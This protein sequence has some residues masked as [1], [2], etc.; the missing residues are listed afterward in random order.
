IIISEKMIPTVMSSTWKEKSSTIGS[1]TNL[2]PSDEEVV[3][4]TYDEVDKTY[5]T[6]PAT[7]A[8]REALPQQKDES[9]LLSY[10]G[11]G[12][13]KRS[14]ALDSGVTSANVSFDDAASCKSYKSIIPK[15]DIELVAVQTSGRYPTKLQKTIQE[16]SAPR[17]LP[18]KE[19]DE[20]FM[21]YSSTPVSL[22]L[23]RSTPTPFKSIRPHSRSLI[24]SKAI[25]ESLN[26][27]RTSSYNEDTGSLLEHDSVHLMLFGKETIL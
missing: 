16:L 7:R 23:P 20:D 21:M 13:R 14:Y 10:L 27:T 3:D 17:V 19:E 24:P 9:S 8:S 22:S 18:L 26:T 2:L 4:I 15:N 25:P 6:R 1:K 12:R 11:I 5:S